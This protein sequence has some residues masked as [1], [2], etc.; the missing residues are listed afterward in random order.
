MCSRFRITPRRK[1]LCVLPE[2]TILKLSKTPKKR[3]Y[4]KKKEII[5]EP[6]VD[7]AFEEL[8]DD[9]GEFIMSKSNDIGEFIMS[10]SEILMN[11]LK[12]YKKDYIN[13]IIEKY[14]G[15]LNA[16]YEYHAEPK[17]LT[18]KQCLNVIE[19]MNHEEYDE[20][21][22][23]HKLNIEEDQLIELIGERTFQVTLQTYNASRTSE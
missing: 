3:Q 2:K 11:P 15:S 7:G 23:D 10:K 17:I 16:M 5:D 14:N 1:K 9:I 6:E 4:K 13:H 19:Y 12:T 18:D 22:N 21:T 8:E 20:N